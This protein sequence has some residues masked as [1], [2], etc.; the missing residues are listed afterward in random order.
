M[1]RRR[2]VHQTWPAAVYAVGDIHGYLGQLEALERDILAD[3]A[4]IAGEKWLVTL[5]DHID[6][7]PASAAVLDHIMKPLP[8]GWRR[9]ALVGNHDQ[10]MIDYLRDPKAHD[11]W[12]AEGGAETL[13][14]YGVDFEA[15]RATPDVDR[16]IH[17]EFRARVPGTHLELLENLPIALSLPGWLF[18]HAGIRPGVPLHRQT[19]DDLIWIRS[20]FLETPRRD[21]L[22]VVHGHTPGAAPVFIDGRIGIDT[23]CYLTGT[24]SAV[25]V[26]P[27]GST[28]V[29]SVS[30]V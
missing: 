7:G 12:L 6:R 13:V 17:K 27:D 28:K 23:H 21:G 2:L 8:V 5:G 22:T 10:I 16:A 11:Y 19:D 29:M 18:V 30:G 3:G 4:A 15:L 9:I 14:S 25:R 26:M 1:P 24:L 20:P